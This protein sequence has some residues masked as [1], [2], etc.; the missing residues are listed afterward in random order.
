MTEYD[1]GGGY[2]PVARA[3]LVTRDLARI[4]ELSREVYVDH[5]IRFRCGDPLR[6]RGDLRWAVADN[7]AAGLASYGGLVC[8]CEIEPADV[9][10]A[11]VLKRGSSAFASGGEELRCAPGRALMV[12][13]D[14][15][16]VARTEDL[17]VATLQVTWAVAG[18]LAEELAGLPAADLRFTGIEPVSAARQAEFAWTVDFICAQLVTSGIRE[19]RPLVAQQLARLAGTALLRTFPNTAL[20]APGRP[21][22]GWVAPAAV[23]RAAA[24]IDAYAGLPVGGDQIAAAAGAP[25]FA[26]RRAFQRRFGTSPQ[27]YLRRVR[28]ER[29]C[30][31]LSRGEPASGVTLTAVAQRWGWADLTQFAVAYRRRFGESPAWPERR[32]SGDGAGGPALP[33][34]PAGHAAAPGRLV[35]PVHGSGLFTDQPRF[36]T[37]G[38]TAPRPRAHAHSLQR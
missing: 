31:E 34:R 33:A 13:A 2:V 14:R 11:A 23:D 27:G 3:E 7:V 10:N 25:V 37:F 18:A 26:L 35:L 6:V 32:L 29:A 8:E 28:L 17:A 5:A 21:D 4:S 12:P 36:R 22:P 20:T 1:M 9:P 16:S 38:K 30:E 19:A 24:F 15:P